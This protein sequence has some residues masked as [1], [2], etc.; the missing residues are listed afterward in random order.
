[1]F[2]FYRL[3][4]LKKRYGFARFGPGEA[5]LFWPESLKQS[6]KS[7]GQSIVYAIVLF[8]L[9]KNIHNEVWVYTEILPLSVPYTGFECSSSKINICKRFVNNM[10]R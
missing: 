2:P 4:R 6:V 10:A 9:K 3:D 7:L 5:T 8:F 1:M